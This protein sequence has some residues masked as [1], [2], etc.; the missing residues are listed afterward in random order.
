MGAGFLREVLL[1]VFMLTSIISGKA[2][3]SQEN[4]HKQKNQDLYPE[5]TLLVADASNQDYLYKKIIH[6]DLHDQ[7]LCLLYFAVLLANSFVASHW[8]SLP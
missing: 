1:L 5:V 4:R 2:I 6:I 3:Y 7:L 8:M